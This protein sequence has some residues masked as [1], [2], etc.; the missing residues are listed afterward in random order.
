MFQERFKLQTPSPATFSRH[1]YP[2]FLQVNCHALLSLIGEEELRGRSRVCKLSFAERCFAP[3]ICTRQA[4]ARA[5]SQVTNSS[6]CEVH[7]Y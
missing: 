1:F 2:P 7:I 5:Q 4:K 6:S 3:L